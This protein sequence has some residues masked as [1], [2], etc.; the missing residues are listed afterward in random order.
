MIVSLVR[1]NSNGVGFL[2]V[3]NRICV[4]LTRAKHGLF[5][6]GNLPFLAYN[7][8]QLWGK[9]ADELTTHKLAYHKL[10]IICQTHGN[11]EVRIFF[12]NY[13]L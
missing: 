2:A 9:I 4:A 5:I 3:A 12:V 6:I 8:P 11:V 1:S 13:Q 7:S 10:P